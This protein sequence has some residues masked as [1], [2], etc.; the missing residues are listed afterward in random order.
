[1][2]A[3]TRP[4]ADPWTARDPWSQPSQPAP[5]A[6]PLRLPDTLHEKKPPPPPAHE[7]G[8][9]VWQI[10]PPNPL[11][12]SVRPPTGETITMGVLASDR[13]SASKA[14]V[15]DSASNSDSWP[16]RLHFSAEGR[17]LDGGER[18]EEYGIQDGAV[19]DLVR[20]PHHAVRKALPAAR[21]A[22]TRGPTGERTRSPA[23]S[24]TPATG[25]GIQDVDI[26]MSGAQQGPCQATQPSSQGVMF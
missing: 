9:K 18:L 24:A 26:D 23:A 12:I 14:K 6:A 10:K 4:A 16:R 11:R 17:Q 8:R 7:A 19:L 13:V 3:A 25:S 2:A 22:P 20:T 5:S 15:I 21:E 1:M